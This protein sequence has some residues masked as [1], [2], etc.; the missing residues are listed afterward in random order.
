VLDIAALTAGSRSDDNRA[1]MKTAYLETCIGMVRPTP[2][3]IEFGRLLLA[4]QWA[5]WSD[6]WTPPP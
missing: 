6:G 5:G 4:A 1:A 3:D 2:R